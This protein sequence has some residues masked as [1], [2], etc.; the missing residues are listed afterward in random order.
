VGIVSG[1]SLVIPVLPEVT[2]L[3]IVYRDYIPNLDSLLLEHVPSRDKRYNSAL[4]TLFKKELYQRLLYTLSKKIQSNKSYQDNK[5]QIK[6][7]KKERR[8]LYTLFA[9]SILRNEVTFTENI[10]PI[11]RPSQRS[12]CSELTKDNCTSDGMCKLSR[13]KCKLSISEKDYT[14]FIQQIG[15]ELNNNL[16]LSKIKKNVLFDKDRFIQNKDV[17]QIVS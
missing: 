13:D 6:K 5:N 17:I 4:V 16:D 11:E 1:S 12:V 3:P 7:T 9:D 8:S 14:Q 2:S 10:K 15:I